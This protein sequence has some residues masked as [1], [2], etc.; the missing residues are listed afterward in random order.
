MQIET[1]HF[2]TVAVEADDIVLFPRG[3]MGLGE[4]LRGLIPWPPRLG[5]ERIAAPPAQEPTGSL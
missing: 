3:L 1:R 4:S 5:G 2:G